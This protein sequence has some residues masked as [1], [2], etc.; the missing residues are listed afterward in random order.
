ML[1][2]FQRLALA[3]LAR[4]ASNNFLPTQAAVAVRARGINQSRLWE[5]KLPRPYGRGL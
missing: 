5:G 1:E 3:A 4:V 2:S